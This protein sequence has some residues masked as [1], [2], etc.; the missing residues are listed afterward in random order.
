MIIIDLP[1]TEYRRVT[2]GEA[3]PSRWRLAWIDVVIA[4]LLLAL[5]AIVAI[6]GGPRMAVGGMLSVALWLAGFRW[7]WAGWLVFIG[8]AAGR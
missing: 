3:P 2:K 6:G 5:F 4:V 7:R 8:W 1:P